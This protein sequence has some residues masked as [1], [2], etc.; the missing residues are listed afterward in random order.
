MADTTETFTNELIAHYHGVALKR[1]IHLRAI[2]KTSIAA[3]T[4]SFGVDYTMA[5]N[6]WAYI[7]LIE[8]SDAYL[9]GLTAAVDNMKDEQ[10]WSAETSARVLY[11]IATDETAKRGERIAAA[12]ELNVMYGITIVDD[13]GNTRAGVMSVEDLF[14]L[15]SQGAAGSTVKH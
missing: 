13:K 10:L 11:S 7:D 12:K 6:P 2:G 15:K 5:M 4:G 1:Y 8:T 3:L 14:R 9:S